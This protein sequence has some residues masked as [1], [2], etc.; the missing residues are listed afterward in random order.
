MRAP[1]I[2]D[3]RR[4][5]AWPAHEQIVDLLDGTREPVWL[6]IFRLHRRRHF[7]NNRK[8]SGVIGKRGGF[9]TPRRSRQRKGRKE[10]PYCDQHERTVSGTTAAVAHQIWK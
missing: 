7:E 4:L 3:Q 2:R 1:R 5:R 6:Y 9:P 8:R 10:P